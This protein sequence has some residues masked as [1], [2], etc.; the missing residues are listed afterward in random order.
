MVAMRR[1]PPAPLAPS[2]RAPSA[3]L[4]GHAEVHP[5]RP[6]HAPEGYGEAAF[7]VR[8]RSD[9]DWRSA[10]ESS[11]QHAAIAS[12]S[13]GA[14]LSSARRPWSLCPLQ[15]P[16]L[17]GDRSREPAAA[18]V[19]PQLGPREVAALEVHWHAP[20]PET[21]CRRT[22]RDAVPRSG[23]NGDGDAEGRPSGRRQHRGRTGRRSSAEDDRRHLASWA[24]GA[25][26]SYSGSVEKDPARAAGDRDRL[27]V[28]SAGEDRDRIAEDRD[29]RAEAHDRV[30][31]AR[32]S[33]ADARD[34]RAEAR[35]RVVGG[36]ESGAA[37][38]RGGA[39]RDREGGASDRTQAADDRTAASA[40]RGFSA[41]E[42]VA[43]AIDELTGA[44]RREVG[45]VE[46]ERDLTRA[47]RTSQPFTLA[48]IDI[49]DLKGR[50]DS[51]GHHAGD[52]LLRA[53]A[54]AIRAYVRPYDLIVR[55][56][57]DEFLCGV[58]DVHMAEA[59][60]RFSRVNAELAATGKASVT[61]GLAELE[62]DDA[63]EDL[64][65]RADQALY[66]ERQRLRSADDGHRFRR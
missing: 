29:R 57:G 8:A 25:R 30:S 51:L 24:T 2:R 45:F 5:V 34:E 47:Q 63:L 26:R 55:F 53:T 60:E 48:F 9:A 20:R 18:T 31:E 36:D 64:V 46:L 1:R 28:N 37:A 65:A 41:Q 23:P 61:I 49:D 40:D 32:D 7:A 3:A 6:Q 22:D 39:K 43:F 54:D 19:R 4:E 52:Q 27:E 62:A 13:R 35:E 58:T 16:G 17:R 59:T 10:R 44:H 14:V 56:G 15:R 38:D 42:R 11:S 12:G 50:N 33:R 66:R 21:A